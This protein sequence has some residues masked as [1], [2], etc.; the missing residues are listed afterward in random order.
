MKKNGKR[1]VWITWKSWWI[2]RNS[3]RKSN[4]A[5]SNSLLIT[6][7]KVTPMFVKIFVLICTE[8]TSE[9]LQELYKFP[10]KC[11]HMTLHFDLQILTAISFKSNPD[12][13]SGRGCVS[14]FDDLWS[15][16]TIVQYIS[17]LRQLQTSPCRRNDVTS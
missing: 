4:L 7:Y 8:C 9:Q 15:S 14:I 17:L 1:F 3:L 6:M 13:V 2:T 16:E 12:D 10:E 5:N 11:R